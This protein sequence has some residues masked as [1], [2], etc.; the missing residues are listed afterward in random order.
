M[1]SDKVIIFDFF[2]VICSEIA[3]PWFNKHFW[4]R[5]KEGLKDFYF[6]TL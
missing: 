3:P 5:K 4:G 1:E 2:G 6:K